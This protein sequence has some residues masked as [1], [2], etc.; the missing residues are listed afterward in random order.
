[1]FG[2]DLDS[3]EETVSIACH[4]GFC[5]FQPVRKKRTTISANPLAFST[6]RKNVVS[7][8]KSLATVPARFVR[9]ATQ[10]FSFA[11]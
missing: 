2:D 6:V 4:S 8:V 5:S 9:T 3:T 11:V 10:S 1:M 7:G